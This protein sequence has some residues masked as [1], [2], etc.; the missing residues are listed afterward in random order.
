MSLKHLIG[1]SFLFQNCHIILTLLASCDVNVARLC[2]V[3]TG[4]VTLLKDY[5]VCKQ[6]DVLTPE[7]TRIL[8]SSGL[9]NPLTERTGVMFHL[10]PSVGVMHCLMSL[11]ATAQSSSSTIEL[12]LLALYCLI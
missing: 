10:S 6:G 11:R 5:E 12:V 3:R 2:N 9:F 4:V 1:V 8:V 7:Q